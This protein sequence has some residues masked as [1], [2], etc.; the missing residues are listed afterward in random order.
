M[1]NS[2]SA[3]RYAK[4]LYQIASSE[5]TQ[6]AVLADIHSYKNAIHSNQELHAVMQSPVIPGSKKKAIVDAIFKASFQKVTCLFFDLV[7]LK[8]RE[9]E[10]SHIAE[11]YIKEDKRVKGIKDGKLVTASPLNDELRSELI[12]RAEK[13]AGSKV[14]I[15]ES[16]DPA[17]IG[18]FILTV[19][20]LQ[21]DESIRTKLSKL[22]LQLVDSSYI[23]KID[24]I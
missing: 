5:G 21:L 17:L 11:A 19:G 20:D 6:E 22:H 1:S 18:G 13:L 12:S 10:L 4:S 15:T 24:L 3:E 2:K 8:G 14:E 16:V 23:P 9:K 7:I